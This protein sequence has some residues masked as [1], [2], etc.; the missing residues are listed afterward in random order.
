MRQCRSE[1]A[2]HGDSP[3]MCDLSP[4]QQRFLLGLFAPSKI[5]RGAAY[6]HR[7]AIG[8]SFDATMGRDPAHL[9]I[10]KVKAKLRIV[11]TSAF[12]GLRQNLLEPIS[13]VGVQPLQNTLEFQPL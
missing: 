4:Q 5:A 3:D 10:R 7:L 13:I 9:A 11:Y 12:E 6:P 1:L 8:V 2:H